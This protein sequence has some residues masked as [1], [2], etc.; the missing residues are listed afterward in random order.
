[1]AE[2]RS[3]DV[4]LEEMRKEREA[5]SESLEQLGTDLREVRQESQRRALEC[6]RQAAKFTGA[7]AGIAGL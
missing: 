5:L 3:R 1:M 4:V 6:G 2:E 7:A